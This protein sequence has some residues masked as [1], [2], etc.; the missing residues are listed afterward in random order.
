MSIV[1]VRS[2]PRRFWLRWLFGL[3]W[4]ITIDVAAVSLLAADLPS[5]PDNYVIV[6]DEDD[7]GSV[8]PE[9]LPADDES[10]EETPQEQEPEKT[11][12]D[13]QKKPDALKKS[14]GKSLEDD[15]TSK[16]STERNVVEDESSA[17]EV[18]PID[19]PAPE[20]P[21]PVD[22]TE[23]EAD[24][25]ETRVARRSNDQEESDPDEIAARPHEPIARPAVEGASFKGVLPATTTVD[26]LEKAWGPPK[27]V[28]KA[29]TGMEH[30]YFMKPF[31]QVVV[32]IVDDKVDTVL[33]HLEKQFEPAVLA[34]QL[35]LD[36]VEPA[37][38]YNSKGQ[39]LG[40]AFPER[41]VLFGF[42]SGT[43]V[44]AAQIVLE[45]INSQPFV[46]RAEKNLRRYPE[47][48]LVDVECAVEIDPQYDRAH[49]VRARVL[50]EMGKNQEALTAA[51]KAASLTAD[52]PEYQ[53]LI[54]KARFALQQYERAEKLAEKLITDEKCTAI[55]MAQ[56]HQV[57]GDAI[58]AGPSRAF[59]KSIAH[60]TE[61]IKL[62]EQVSKSSAGPVR[63]AAKELLVDAH[64]AVAQDVAW[65]NW[66]QKSRVVPKWIDRANAFCNNLEGRD[67][68]ALPLRFRVYE[69]TLHAYA[70]MKGSPDCTETID[71]LTQLGRKLV[72][73]ETNAVR[74][75]TLAWRLGEAMSSAMLIA[76]SQNQPD[77]GSQ[78][79]QQAL[80]YFE[81]AGKTGENWPGREHVIGRVYYR[82][83][84]MQAV[85]QSE[86]KKAIAWYDKAVPLLEAPAP[87]DAVADQGRVG[88]M[89]VSMGVSYWEN[90]NR[91]E[92]VRLTQ[93]GAK[94]MESA[95]D[96]EQLP[97]T[98]L[99]VP[100]GNLSSMHAGLGD[101][102]QSKR[103]AEM[104]AK[105]ET[106]RR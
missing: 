26:E 67:S 40:M 105:V 38:I 36:D 6:S 89:F 92:A 78:Y 37:T 2:R 94:L 12:T 31:K 27:E 84:A 19:K 49:A 51:E 39:M 5:E 48:A 13:G 77:A 73:N 53:L 34:K 80:A 104:A 43:P 29:E 62:A 32:K 74:R 82:L 55:V 90:G 83:G 17:E 44:R 71:K 22:E 64:L 33:I 69:H 65:G 8:E 30:I 58:V 61:A 76:Q 95:V 18:A 75:Q 41:G 28:R 45:P 88:E 35:L 102:T 54:V 20:V 79:G 14:G 3:C 87:P 91:E 103:F 50:L 56:A 57:W 42:A 93:Q 23:V 21:P 85:D 7:R 100:Y 46:T 4:M 52:E 10:A 101:S 98:A 68:D 47:E 1:S 96:D 24:E 97:Q 70:G 11:S 81:Q 63:R 106:I 15:T 16:E 99:L 72:E 59:D 60:H 25:S 86:H 66:Q 9:R